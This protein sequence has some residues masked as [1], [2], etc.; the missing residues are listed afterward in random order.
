MLIC[1]ICSS[2]LLPTIQLECLLECLSHLPST[3]QSI[4]AQF[5]VRSGCA[6]GSCYKVEVHMDRFGYVKRLSRGVCA[7]LHAW[8]RGP[9]W[10]SFIPY[11]MEVLTFNLSS[12][13]VIT[14]SFV[15]LT[16]FKAIGYFMTWVCLTKIIW[17]P[18]GHEPSKRL[19]PGQR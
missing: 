17:F 5:V 1:P 8:I 2:L 13:R 10:Q 19:A 15:L 7:F 12:V 3:L 4:A 18:F 14:F 16:V 9:W 6:V 11:L